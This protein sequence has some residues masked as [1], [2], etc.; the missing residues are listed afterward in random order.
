MATLKGSLAKVKD[1]LPKLV[2]PQVIQE[3]CAQVGYSW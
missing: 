1:D 2:S 3:S